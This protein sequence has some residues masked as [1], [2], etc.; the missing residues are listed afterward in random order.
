MTALSRKQLWGQKYLRR[1]TKRCSFSRAPEGLQKVQSLGLIAHANHHSIQPLLAQSVICSRWT[2]QEVIVKSK[3]HEPFRDS[4]FCHQLLILPLPSS[5]LSAQIGPLT[6]LSFH[7]DSPALLFHFPAAFAIFPD[8]Q[9][10]IKWFDRQNMYS[11][12]HLFPINIHVELLLTSRSY[13]HTHKGGW[14]LKWSLHLKVW[15]ITFSSILTSNPIFHAVHPQQGW[16]GKIITFD[17]ISI[18][19]LCN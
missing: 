5:F 14:P 6:L 10:N 19:H 11:P 7:L 12:N 4:F 15:Q 17:M 2:G 9:L 13:A 18:V 8:V 16:F 3:I 1:I